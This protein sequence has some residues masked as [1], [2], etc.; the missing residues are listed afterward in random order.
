MK[1]RTALWMV[2]EAVASGRLES[3][4]VILEATSGN[5]GIG[6]AM[7]GAALGYPVELVVPDEVSGE[8][9]ETMLAFGAGVVRSTG[10]DGTDGARELAAS[11]N[12][13]DPARYFRPDQYSSRAKW[14]GHF[15]TTGPEIIEQ[16]I[17]SVEAFMA[18]IGTGGTLMGVGRRLREHNPK[19]RLLGVEPEPGQTIQGLRSTR[20]ARVP[21]LLRIG[22]LDVIA[23]V[24]AERALLMA[25]RPI[26]AG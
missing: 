21:S 6:L 8:R 20:S 17:G 4:M 3:G 22:M 9:I 18:G 15:R 2:K 26:R 23:P 7:V 11:I 25:R 1:G 14:L 12:R 19:T 16:T 24:S 5:T 13:D 10:D